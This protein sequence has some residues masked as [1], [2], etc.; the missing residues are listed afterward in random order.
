MAK[1]IQKETTHEDAAE[2][3]EPPT[4]AGPNPTAQGLDQ[5]LADIDDV[6]EINALSFVQGFVQKGGQ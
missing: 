1:R 2:P 5:V 3:I 6:L 4:P